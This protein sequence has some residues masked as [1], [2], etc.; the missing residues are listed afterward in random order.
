M[1]I[2]LCHAELPSE[3]QKG[4]KVL[5]RVV[6]QTITNMR[7]DA[8]ELA[9][10][11]I[12]SN[13]KANGHPDVRS[14]LEDTYNKLMHC[15]GEKKLFLNTKEEFIANLEEC[16]KDAIRKTENCLADDQKYFP[17]FILEL[18]KSVV[19]LLYDDFQILKFDFPS[20]IRFLDS[21]DAA[22]KFNKCLTDTAAATHETDELPSSRKSY[23]DKFL[24]ATRCFSEMI[25][26]NCDDTANFR[27]FREDYMNAMEVP[28]GTKNQHKLKSNSSIR[29]V[30][31]V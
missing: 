25:K 30:N 16:S 20:C 21:T 13:C 15:V 3:D 4:H 28:C 27:K 2:G 12:V 1:I 18:A 6:R 22:R 11:I 17:E 31:N 23:C 14:E 24:P 29:L 19:N 7:R 26:D 5:R 9:E 8:L 10:K